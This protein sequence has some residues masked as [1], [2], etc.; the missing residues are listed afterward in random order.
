MFTK[1]IY[2][3]KT[4][5]KRQNYYMFRLTD[6]KLKCDLKSQ[7]INPLFRMKGMSFT[8][9]KGKYPRE[10]KTC[11]HRNLFMNVQC[12]IIHN[13]PPKKIQRPSTDEYI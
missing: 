6:G 8:K 13:I 12:S 10:M 9:Q 11:P 3:Y 1:E 5:I 7:N 4:Q 2:R